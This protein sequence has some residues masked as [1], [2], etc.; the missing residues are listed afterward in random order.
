MK[1]AILLVA[2]AALGLVAVACSTASELEVSKFDAGARWSFANWPLTVNAATLGCDR[3]FAAYV[4]VED[5]RYDLNGPGITKY[6]RTQPVWADNPDIPGTKK[7]IGVLL[8][9]ALALCDDSP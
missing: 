3:P 7:N 2:L 5:R 9:P 6:G 8:D 4:E 1:I